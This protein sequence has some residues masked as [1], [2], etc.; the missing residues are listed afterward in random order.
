MHI[1]QIPNM[2]PDTALASNPIFVLSMPLCHGCIV[3][4]DRKSTSLYKRIAGMHGQRM[5]SRAYEPARALK[6][7]MDCTGSG[8]R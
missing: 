3:E 5:Q 2:L 1:P 6:M 7:Y 8:R 4:H